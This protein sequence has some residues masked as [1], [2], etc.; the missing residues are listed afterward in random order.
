MNPLVLVLG[1]GGLIYGAYK[2]GSK[3]S[4]DSVNSLPPYSPPSNMPTGA[5]NVSTSDPLTAPMSILDVQKA[6]NSIGASPP[7]VEDGVKGPKTTDA[8]KSFQSKMGLSVDGI[9]GPN[10]WKALRQ[11]VL[12]VHSV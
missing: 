10:T 4:N 11:A 9:P 6:L 12:A 1:L 5:T 7:L 8:I 2:I 3:K